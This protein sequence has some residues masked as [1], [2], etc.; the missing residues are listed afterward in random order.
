MLVLT[1]ILTRESPTPVCKQEIGRTKKRSDD[2][3][4]TKI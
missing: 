4:A 3:R 1:N 2:I